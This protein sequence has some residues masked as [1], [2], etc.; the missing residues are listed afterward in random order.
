MVKPQPTHSECI[1]WFCV[2][3]YVQVKDHEQK[4]RQTIYYIVYCMFHPYADLIIFVGLAL[5]L[6]MM[7]VLS[8]LGEEADRSEALKVAAAF[9]RCPVSLFSDNKNEQKRTPSRRTSRPALFGAMVAICTLYNPVCVEP[10]SAK[11]LRSV[12]N[13]FFSEKGKEDSEFSLFLMFFFQ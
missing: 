10:C 6:A 1:Q 11:S 4:P 5:A 7:F 9:W 8:F 3:P 13:F 2:E 12:G